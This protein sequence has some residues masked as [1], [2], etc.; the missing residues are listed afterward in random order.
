VNNNKNTVKRR[1][2]SHERIWSLIDLSGG[3]FD[4]M[5]ARCHSKETASAHR[6][7]AVCLTS[8]LGSDVLVALWPAEKVVMGRAV[9]HSLRTALAKAPCIHLHLA[10]CET[11][12]RQIPELKWLD[13]LLSCCKLH[14]KVSAAPCA[15]FWVMTSKPSSWAGIVTNITIDGTRLSGRNILSA[16]RFRAFQN[17]AGLSLRGCMLGDTGVKGLFQGL[18]GTHL[19]KLDLSDTG[20][21][22]VAVGHLTEALHREGVCLQHLALANN[23]FFAEGGR[24]LATEL[25]TSCLIHLDLSRSA[26]QVMLE[27]KKETYRERE[28]RVFAEHIGL[29]LLP[30]C[31]ALQCLD[32]SFRYIGDE[33]AQCVAMGITQACTRLTSLSLGGNVWDEAGV[34]HLASTLPCVTSLTAFRLTGKSVPPTHDGEPDSVSAGLRMCTN[35][36]VLEL[37]GVFAGCEGAHH[38]FNALHMTTLLK[39]LSLTSGGLGAHSGRRLGVLLSRC[40]HL[41]TLNLAGNSIDEPAMG[42]LA[43]GL[44]SNLTALG[45][46]DNALGDTGAKVLADVVQQRLPLLQVLH[47]KANGI[48]MDGLR[49]LGQSMCGRTLQ[50]FSAEA[51]G[52][53][54]LRVQTRKKLKSE[55]E[56]M[57][58]GCTIIL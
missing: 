58:H 42:H 56:K 57:M 30:R 2:P 1:R 40:P 48:S 24:K 52:H 43:A 46:N 37:S 9:C 39:S 10:C 8:V 34:Q 28:G 13:T 29:E 21:G 20:M 5:S 7:P 22:D 19:K 50:R 53:A 26:E 18:R 31:T 49:I 16:E 38:L 27:L 17:L 4:K 32:L 45:L 41:M 44:Q 36:R 35:I 3:H 47:I 11:T 12:E 6:R 23:L 33:G 54:S 15:S 25:M 55:L 51:N 14:L